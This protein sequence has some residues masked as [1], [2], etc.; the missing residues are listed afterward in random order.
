M[1]HCLLAFYLLS[2]I[3]RHT[4]APKVVQYH[5]H[6]RILPLSVVAIKL[7]FQ[8]IKLVRF[9]IN[10]LTLI[11]CMWNVQTQLTNYLTTKTGPMATLMLQWPISNQLLTEDT[12]H[13]QLI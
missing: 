8:S 3:F 11:C 6:T 1:H 7:C 2:A 9:D 12:Y 4:M 13:E 5:A 10:C